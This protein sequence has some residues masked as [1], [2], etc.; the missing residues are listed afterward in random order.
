MIIN[1]INTG[2]IGAVQI[3]FELQVIGGICKDQVDRILW[4]AVHH[5]DAIARLNRIDRKRGL[6]LR[7]CLVCH[8]VP[9]VPAIFRSVVM[10]QCESKLIRGQILFLNNRLVIFLDTRCCGQV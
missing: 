4:Q 10:G 6:R 1:R 2:V 3:T 8:I 5:F 9:H 7:C